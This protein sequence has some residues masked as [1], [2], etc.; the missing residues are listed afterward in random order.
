MSNKDF[1]TLCTFLRAISNISDRFLIFDGI[2]YTGSVPQNI[3]II[4]TYRTPT[5]N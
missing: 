3:N 2:L 1:I 5:E 4:H